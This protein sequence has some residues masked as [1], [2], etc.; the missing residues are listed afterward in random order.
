MESEHH[1]ALKSLAAAFLIREGFPAVATEVRCPGSRYRVDAA[2]YLDRIPGPTTQ[3]GSGAPTLWSTIAST[4]RARRERRCEPRTI[5]IECKQSRSDFIR[6]DRRADELIALRDEARHW[7]RH[8][9]ERR[10]KVHEPELRESGSALFTELETW[11]FSSSRLSSYRKLLRRIRR[12]EDQLYGETKFCLMSR[13]RV[14][15]QLYL[16]VPRGLIRQR[17]APD[18]WGVVE[19]PHARSRAMPLKEDA[20]AE[21]HPQPITHDPHAMSPDFTLGLRVLLDAPRLNS[22]PRFRQLLLR[23]I[24]VAATR[25]SCRTPRNTG[26]NLPPASPPAS[27]GRT[28]AAV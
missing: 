7:K 12:I 21:I 28:S 17:E 6:D 3:D 1:V 8:L 15:D 5:I 18:G 22:P 20:P 14:A 16:L 9:E 13:Y 11:N 2:G 24:A 4:S 27:S 26:H 19:A 10:I 23:N 25:D